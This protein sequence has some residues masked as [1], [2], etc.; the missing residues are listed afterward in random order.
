MT[1]NTNTWIWLD[2]LS[3]GEVEDL[4]A[5]WNAKAK[6]RR[7]EEELRIETEFEYANQIPADWVVC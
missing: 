5:Y 1:Y 2:W 7:V 6:W 3:R 4:I